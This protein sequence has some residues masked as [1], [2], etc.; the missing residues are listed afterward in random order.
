MEQKLA[1]TDR[2]G[3]ISLR[4]N[5]L[6]GGA[7][8]RTV[9]HVIELLTSRTLTI[10]FYAEQCRKKEAEVKNLTAQLAAANVITDAMVEA[11]V[12]AYL[13]IATTF[14]RDELTP[15]QRQ[16]VYCGIWDALIAADAAR[17]GAR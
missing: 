12:S 11:G 6:E 2:I 3:I 13:R 8:P 15:R 7:N 9:G 4:N 1:E 16:I 17:T 5:L 14:D 10:Y